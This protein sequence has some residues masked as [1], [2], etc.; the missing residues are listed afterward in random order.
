MNLYYRIGSSYKEKQPMEY[1]K[2]HEVLSKHDIISNFLKV[3]K[4]LDIHS[5]SRLSKNLNNFWFVGHFNI[6]KRILEKWKIKILLRSMVHGHY[7]LLFS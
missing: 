5:Q 7:S 1:A 4:I 2:I 6:Q 3:I